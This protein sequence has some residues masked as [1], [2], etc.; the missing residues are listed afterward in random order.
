MLRARTSPPGAPLGRWWARRVLS[1]ARMM[2]NGRNS[3]MRLGVV[4]GGAA[5]LSAALA[6]WISKDAS[7]MDRRTEPGWRQPEAGSR[8]TPH[9]IPERGEWDSANQILKEPERRAG[10]LAVAE[11]IR[12]VRDYELGTTK[13]IADLFEICRVPEARSQAVELCLTILVSE[14]DLGLRAAARTLLSSKLRPSDTWALTRAGQIKL[15]HPNDAAVRD[16]VQILTGGADVAASKRAAWT[17]H[18]G[19]RDPSVR[20]MM[21]ECS[22]AFCESE[23]LLGALLQL[24]DDESWS[25]KLAAS[26]RISSW[27]SFRGLRL[28]RLREQ[29]EVAD[30]QSALFAASTIL[31]IEPRSEI[32]SGVIA[33][34]ISKPE[35]GPLR[36][37][38]AAVSMIPSLREWPTVASKCLATA[39]EQEA[40]VAREAARVIRLLGACDTRI[41]EA[42]RARLR[43]PIATASGSRSTADSAEGPV[44]RE[45][46]AV[47]TCFPRSFADAAAI[48][49]RHLSSRQP[50][51][52][53]GAIEAARKLELHV[54]IPVAR[55]RAVYSEA[56]RETQMRLELHFPHIEVTD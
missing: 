24:L 31:T 18:L 39:L 43:G 30:G 23:G 22:I 42:V 13:R 25:V 56:E 34:T 9:S 8:S 44:R 55:Y 52:L 47:V 46:L 12:N 51:E 26:A 21:V 14:S 20:K 5:L 7:R 2:R 10:P 41:A 16:F 32:A 19:S 33:A 35:D 37:R 6:L 15:L 1:C 4:A 48:V 28:N 29:L 53:L 45:L 17:T 3:R 11:W 54:R 49:N 36:D 27:R 50:E 38:V 40:A